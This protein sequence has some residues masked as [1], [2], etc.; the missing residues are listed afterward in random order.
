MNIMRENQLREEIFSPETPRMRQERLRKALGALGIAAGTVIVG[1]SGGV[2]AASAFPAE[3][4]VGNIYQAEVSLSASPAD[5]SRIHLTT[6]AGDL[7]AAFDSWSLLSPGIRIT[8]RLNGKSIEMTQQANFGIESFV[9]SASEEKQAITSAAEQLAL[10]FGIGVI[11]AEALLLAGAS[12]YKRGRPSARQLVAGTAAGALAFGV[13]AGQAVF[14]YQP[15]NY[16]SFTTDG[17]LAHIYDN[18]SL[19]S[20]IQTRSRQTEPFISSLLALSSELQQKFVTPES[21]QQIAAKF[22]L[23]SDMHGVNQDAMLKKIIDEQGITAVI[24]TGDLTNFGYSEELDASGFAAS[25][26]NL[27]VP[28]LFVRG[29]HD[30]SSPNAQAVLTRLAQIPNVI[31]L[32][33][34]ANTYTQASINGVTIAGF[35]DPR[36]F[37]DNNKDNNQKQIPAIARFNRSFADLPAPDI[38][39]THEPYAAEGVDKAGLTLAGHLHQADLKT[40]H[41][42]IGSFTGGGLFHHVPNNKEGISTDPSYELD[43]LTIDS[44]CR[45]QSLTRFDFRSLVEGRPQYDSVANINGEKLGFK[46]GANRHCDAKQGVAITSVTAKNGPIEALPA[47]AAPTAAP[48][49]SV[50]NYLEVSKR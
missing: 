5:T 44:S 17:L 4:S 35:N 6:T 47:I 40:N 2:I 50:P 7:E 14:D 36:Y 23:V 12:L 15:D 13:A 11:A 24:N 9:P 25:I 28:Y 38:V 49:A 18:R 33:P 29:N 3:V 1:Y 32:Q 43:I 34:D 10:R 39:A 48:T 20:N 16:S 45:A 30:Q 8:P 37:G 41:I 26:E 21:N 31:L 22:L 27:R 42:T 46:P 19:M